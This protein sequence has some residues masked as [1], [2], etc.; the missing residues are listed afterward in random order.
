MERGQGTRA[1]KP[2]RKSAASWPPLKKVD[3]ISPFDLTIDHDERYE[4]SQPLQHCPHITWPH[5]PRVSVPSRR[6]RDRHT[7]LDWLRALVASRAL[8]RNMKRSRGLARIPHT[9][10]GGCDATL[11][12]PRDCLNGVLASLSV[13][14]LVRNGPQGVHR[15]G[16]RRR[17][18]FAKRY[19][20]W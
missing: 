17:R 9:V 12:A 14:L 20:L 7:A 3:R 13:H 11:W 15:A 4:L 19:C 5:A 8:L 18:P 2:T 6:S 1:H 10:Q 16:G